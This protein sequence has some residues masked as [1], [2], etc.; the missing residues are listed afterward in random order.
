MDKS[1]NNAFIK[2]YRDGHEDMVATL[3]DLPQADVH[4]LEEIFEL[5]TEGDN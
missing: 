2:R 3:D 4:D 5:T 1:I